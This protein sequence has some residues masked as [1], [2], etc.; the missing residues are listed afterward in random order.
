MKG[1]TPIEEL[2]RREVFQAKGHDPLTSENIKIVTSRS[3]SSVVASS[4]KS[5]AQPPFHGYFHA[6]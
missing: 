6:N 3:L 4:Y 5:R 1:R 2:L